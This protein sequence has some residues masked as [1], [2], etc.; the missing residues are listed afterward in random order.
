M[1]EIRDLVGIFGAV[2]REAAADSS[3][4][5]RVGRVLPLYRRS[6]V[7]WFDDFEAWTKELR[8]EHSDTPPFPTSVDEG[9]E[10]LAGTPTTGRMMARRMLA[11]AAAGQ[12][13][14]D[15]VQT[16]SDTARKSSAARALAPGLVEQ[17][18]DRGRAVVELLGRED[19]L[20]K[21]DTPE[22]RDAWWHDVLEEARQQGHIEEPERTIGPRPCAGRVSP[23]DCGL[24]ATIEAGFTTSYVKFDRATSFLHPTNWPYCSGGFWCEMEDCGQVSPGVHHFHEVVSTDCENKALAWTI[25]AELDFK[26]TQLPDLAIAEYQLSH[27]HPKRGDAVLVDEG[28]LLVHKLGGGEVRIITTKRVRFDYPF[29]VEALAMIMCALGYATLVEDLVFTCAALKGRKK[30]SEFPGGP[31]TRTVPP[32]KHPADEIAD[33]VKACID[34]YAETARAAS[35]KTAAGT[36]TADALAQDMAQ[37]WVHA[38]REWSDAV[39]LATRS[40][41][42]AGSRAPRR[43]PGPRR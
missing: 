17:S 26:F 41:Q 19:L 20:P 22:A 40:A 4:R 33:R 38:A 30:G 14:P 16:D 7:R 3:V 21:E 15:V 42:A 39:Q 36:Y 37:I 11:V 1:G 23:A 34:H 24:V 31:P 6:D 27:G 5:A 12:A 2:D 32:V 43:R 25:S 8:P 29:S 35:E 10:G 13:F 18:E 28:S 9:L